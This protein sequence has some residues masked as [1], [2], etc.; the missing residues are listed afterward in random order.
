LLDI[1]YYHGIAPIVDIRTQRLRHALLP[2]LIGGARRQA[3]FGCQIQMAIVGVSQADQADV[4][5]ER[6]QCRMECL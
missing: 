2:D 3:P 6:G 5:I 1:A 4:K